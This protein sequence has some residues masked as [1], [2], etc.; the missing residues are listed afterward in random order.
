M[1]DESEPSP[2]ISYKKGDDNE[3]SS[4]AKSVRLETEG[5]ERGF[6]GDFDLTGLLIQDISRRVYRDAVD[7]YF[8]MKVGA[9]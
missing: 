3:F 4:L 1:K 2:S 7:S 6:V 8:V 9:C 5:S